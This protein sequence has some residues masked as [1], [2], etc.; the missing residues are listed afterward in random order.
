MPAE[1]SPL[2]MGL[3]RLSIGYGTHKK[4]RP[5]SPVEAGRLLRRLRDSG[6][7]LQECADAAKT[8]VSTVG[9]FLRVVGLPQDLQHLVEWGKRRGTVGL[10]C[11]VELT[12]FSNTED[13]RIVAKAILADGLDSKEVRQVGQLRGRSSRPVQ[14]CVEEVLGM[15]TTIETRYVFMGS[16]ADDDVEVMLGEISQAERDTILMAGVDAL[17]LDVTSGRLGERL[18]TLVG[19]DRFDESMKSIGKDNVEKRLRTHIKEAVRNGRA[20][21]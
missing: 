13:Q 15:R 8:G 4:A 12:V 1:L 9:R 16:I 3:L 20:G 17:D 6:M 19:G 5:L 10:S 7:S 2:E 11:A 14:E 21:D 18:F